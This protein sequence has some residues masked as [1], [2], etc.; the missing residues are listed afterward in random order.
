MQPFRKLHDDSESRAVVPKLTRWLRKFPDDPET[1]QCHSE[2]KRAVPKTT[3]RPRKENQSFRKKIYH[4][5]KLLSLCENFPIFPKTAETPRKQIERLRKL[6]DRYKCTKS[7]L[8]LLWAGDISVDVLKIPV[9]VLFAINVC[10]FLLDS[11]TGHTIGELQSILPP[12][13]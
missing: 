6:L 12:Y 11:L 8:D 1:L 10:L 13:F 7:F 2:K 5:E 3:S 9:H 4:P